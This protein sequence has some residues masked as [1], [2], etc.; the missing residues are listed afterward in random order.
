MKFMS[1]NQKAEKINKLRKKLEDTIGDYYDLTDPKVI[2]ASR[3]LDD[4]IYKH[5]QSDMK[6]RLHD[7]NNK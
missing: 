1:Y 7:D 2:K 4:L 3:R 5:H 6:T